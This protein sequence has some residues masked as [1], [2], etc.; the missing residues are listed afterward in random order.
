VHIFGNPCDMGAIQDIARDHNLLIIEDCAQAHDA[1]INNMH[2]GTFGDIGAFS[3]YGT[4][5]LIG[6]EGGA[7][8]CN[9][10]ELLIKMNSLKN[11]GRNPEGGYSH[12]SIGYNYRTTDMS[13][14]IMNVQMDRAEEILTRRHKN[15]NLYRKLLSDCEKIRYQQILPGHQHSDYIFATILQNSTKSPLDVIQF[16]KSKNISSRTIYNILSYEQPAYQNIHEWH[17]ARVVKYPN[18]RNCH[19]PEAESI[20]RNHFE[21]PMVSSL[22]D[23]NIEYIVSAIR[24]YL[25]S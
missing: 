15:G 14:A 23:E 2:V 17:M 25:C 3:F 9:N 4:K 7:L 22:T 10:E 5:N 16:L 21:L 20:A 11:H 1:R 19:C 24:E 18:Y 12:F 8:V 13:A 6:G